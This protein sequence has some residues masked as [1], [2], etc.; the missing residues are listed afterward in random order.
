M[1]LKT[2]RNYLII[3]VIICQ[4][5]LL[6]WESLQGGV[7]THN[8]LARADMP[9]ISNWWG[10]LTL[11]FLVWL[12]AH[13]IEQRARRLESKAART[14]L[15]KTSS[16]SF[17]I[18][19]LVS[20]ISSTM[21]S[22]GYASIALSLLFVITFAS[23]FFPLYRLEAII[24]YVLGGAYFTG[25]M[26]PFVGVVLFATVSALVHLCFKPLITRFKASKAVT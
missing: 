21:F 3:T 16:L 7:V 18:M 1:P 13:N 8:F 11:P 26:I 25:P 9:G 5:I 22:L 14:K 23:L 12:G 10:L 15:Y 2:I 4:I 17:L 20:I 24:G 6:T 19:L